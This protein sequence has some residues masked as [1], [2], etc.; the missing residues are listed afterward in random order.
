[1]NHDMRTEGRYFVVTPLQADIDGVNADLVDISTRGARLQVTQRIAIGRPVPF[2]LRTSDA[3]IATT[4]TAVWCEMAA[5]SLHDD[6]MDRYFCGVSFDHS[7]SVIRHLIEDLVDAHTAIPIMDSRSATRYRV[8]APLCASFGEFG[9]LRVLDLSI[10]GARLMTPSLLKT[11]SSGRLRFAIN[12][13][14][15]HVWLPATVMWSRPADRK[16]RFE[17]GLRITDAE[18]WL[19]TV[20]DELSLRDGVVIEPDSL[21]RKF[22]PLLAHPVGGLVGLRR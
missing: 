16:G 1:M 3:T 7:L 18:D 13:D 4:A 15:T 22:D 8:I 11:G 12:G 14:D 17:A 19:R 6:E 20:I 10:R 9:T 21:M 2:T 5:L